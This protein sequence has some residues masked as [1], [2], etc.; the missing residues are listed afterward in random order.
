[1]I[2]KTLS[3]GIVLYEKN[4]ILLV[5]HT[6]QARLPTGS[7]GFPA[8]RVEEGETPS[9]A[10][11]RELEEETGLTTSPQYLIP[12]PEQRSKLNLKSGPEEF[13]FQPFFCIKYSGKLRSSEKTVPE[14]ISLDSLDDLLLVAEDVR[15]ISRQYC[16]QPLRDN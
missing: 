2:K 15:E 6:E 8:G 11:A 16:P 4:R 14:F 12:L 7:Y 9:E 13:I 3:A 5:R 1:M 10:A